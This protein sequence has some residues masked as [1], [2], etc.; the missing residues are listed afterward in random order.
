M[1][2]PVENVVVFGDSVARGYG[3][4]NRK[5]WVSVLGAH[6]YELNARNPHAVFFDASYPGDTT[7]SL[8]QRVEEELPRRVRQ[9]RQHLSVVAL[10]GQD[11]FSALKEG[12]IPDRY[13][14][15]TTQKI[16]GN[17][18]RAA[19]VLGKYGMTLVVG[20]TVC[21]TELAGLYGQSDMAGRDV[22]ILKG[23]CWVNI[24]LH[25]AFDMASVSQLSDSLFAGDTRF[26]FASMLRA[27]SQDPQFELGR[28]GIHPSE[29]GHAW[30]YSRIVPLFD[31]L[32]QQ[33]SPTYPPTLVD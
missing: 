12:G 20:P 13:G 14:H 17:T 18:L 6:Y 29:Q 30:L 3:I 5:S 22:D 8:A 9:G 2:T 27:S 25:E 28:D 15:P 24:A 7:A 1:A 10:G 21:K 4:S 16:L 31:A 19:E 11:L 33:P 23:L 26:R 32:V